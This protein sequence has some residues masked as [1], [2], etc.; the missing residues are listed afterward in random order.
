[1]KYLRH[2]LLLTLA[3][4]PMLAHATGK[5]YTQAEFDALQQAGKPILIFVHANWCPTCRAQAPIL[6]RL[7][8]TPEFSAITALRVD[9]DQQKPVVRAFRVPYQSTLIVFKDGAE[10][11]RSTA[12]TRADKLESLLRNAIDP[13]K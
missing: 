13:S 9:F 10:V 1:M 3:L 5:A 7:L 11:A 6:D 8:S 2:A 12:E 4:L